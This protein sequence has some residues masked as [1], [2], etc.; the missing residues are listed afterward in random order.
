MEKFLISLLMF[1]L[2]TT[3]VYAQNDVKVFVNKL[4]D[5]GIVE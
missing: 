2:T 1:F 3:A 5:A 4:K